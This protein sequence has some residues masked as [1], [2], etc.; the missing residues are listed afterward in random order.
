[1]IPFLS[2][3]VRRFHNTG[4]S[5]YY[6]FI[7]F[8]PFNG[9]VALSVYLCLDSEQKDNVFGPS[10]KYISSDFANIKSQELLNKN[11]DNA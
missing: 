3:V 10:T 11:P 2:C 9:M 8:I 5:G 1:M 7:T 4:R 6:F